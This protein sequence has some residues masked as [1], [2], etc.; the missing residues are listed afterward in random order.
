M[1]TPRSRVPI[2]VW[3]LALGGTGFA[4]G[5]FGPMIFNPYSNIAP[6]VGLLFTGPGGAVAG[7]VLGVLFNVAGVPGAVQRKVLGGA[8]T[9][10]GVG[11]LLYIM[12]EPGRVADIIDATVAECAPPRAFASEAL[13][14]WE[15]AVA[16]AT[17]RAVDP[18]WRS[19][20]LA[21]LERDPGVV[22]TMHVEREATIYRHR[23]PWSF[24]RRFI[25]E[26]R[27]PAEP[28]RRF[29]ASD[30]GRS[31]AAYLSRERRLYM[32]FTE[33]TYERALRETP[34]R[35]W[36]PAGDVPAFLGLMELRPVPEEYR[37][38]VEP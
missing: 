17:R 27:T 8:C 6:I 28:R 3:V 32:P 31:C 33:W 36:P 30:E 37:R 20:A 11:T 15:P 26:W 25:S 12:P 5:F 7:L 9:V 1:S 18:S 14:E 21:N 16:R 4:A 35:E 10:L 13:A 34:P 2:H 29:Y 22:L 19:K 38:F 24:G 23:K